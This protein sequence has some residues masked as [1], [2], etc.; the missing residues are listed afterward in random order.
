MAKIQIK[1]NLHLNAGAPK[2]FTIGKTVTVIL[3]STEIA[4]WHE[5]GGNGQLLRYA[6]HS[7]G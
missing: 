6:L 7:I 1:R 3:S 5:I 2:K 4:A